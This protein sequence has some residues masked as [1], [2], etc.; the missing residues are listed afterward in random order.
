M[1]LLVDLGNSRLKWCTERDGRLSPVSAIDY[2]QAN[3]LETLRQSWSELSQP[4]DLAISSVAHSALAQDTIKL[5]TALWPKV[6]LYRAK[7]AAYEHGVRNAYAEPARLGVD[8][9]LALL[10]AHRHYPGDVC[11]VDCGT[12]V[13]FDAVTAD[14]QH[15]GGLICPGLNLMRNAL[16]A[17]TANLPLQTYAPQTYLAKATEPAIANGVLLAA[18]GMVALAAKQLVGTFRVLITGGDADLLGSALDQPATIDPDLVLKGLALVC[19]GSY[20]R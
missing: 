20:N 2:K 15:L 10:A 17:N 12:A 14:G 6:N 11:V 5:A 8:R 19:R 13:T 3:G 1:K 4:H 18:A 7:S 9:W 16:A